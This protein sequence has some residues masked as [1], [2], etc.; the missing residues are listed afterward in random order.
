MS[1]L[2]DSEDAEKKR[3]HDDILSD[4]SSTDDEDLVNMDLKNYVSDEDPDYEVVF[5][6]YVQTTIA[7]KGV[8]CFPFGLC[9]RP[10][11]LSLYRI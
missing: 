11:V 6:I 2:M 5:I 9:A 1:P 3:K 7:C 8:E 4:D 10:F